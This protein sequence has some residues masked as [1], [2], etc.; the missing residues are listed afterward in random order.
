MMRIGDKDARVTEH[1]SPPPRRRGIAGGLVLLALVLA[2]LAGWRGWAWWEVR[3]V[4]ERV[5]LDV[6]EQRAEA[7]QARIEAAH[8]ELR[9]QAQRLQDAAATNRIL[10]EEMLGLS[11]RGALLEEAVARLAASDRQGT[12]ALRLEETAS[13]LTQA[14]QRIE[15]AGDLAG[16]SRAYALAADALAAIDDP[17]L[18]DLRQTLAQERAALATYGQGPQAEWDARL[19]AFAAALPRLPDRGQ[20]PAPPRAAWQRL[21]APLVDIR[22][23]QP[24]M[25]IAPADR[26]AGIAALEIEISL[27]RAALERQDQAGLQVALARAE[28]WLPR[29]WP[30]SPALRQRRGE[31]E[32]L[33]QVPLQP[34]PPEL[35]STL[36]Q[37]RG[38]AA[39]RSEP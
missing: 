6:A 9:V 11:Q 7:L 39:G 29:L 32:A 34:R 17:T 25:A 3:E 30:D 38:L 31:L 13:L 10:R 24:G 4:R 2:G 16:A 5:A 26:E 18:L 12:R 22:P 27:A 33:R 1:A 21:L 15:I 28:A 23:S 35:G 19:Q 36:Q 37:L 8:R 14:A 20:A